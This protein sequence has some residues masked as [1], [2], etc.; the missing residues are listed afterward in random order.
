MAT[1][2]KS[3]KVSKE[4][5]WSGQGG[6][7]NYERCYH[8]HPPLKVGDWVI[9]GGS[10]IYPVVA[11][12]DVYIGFDRDMTLSERKPWN[13]VT[14]EQVFFPV[15]DGSVPQDPDEFDRL[16][17]WTIEQL[18][19]GKKVHVGCIGGHGRTGMFLA[20]LYAKVTNEADAIT[21]VRKNYC[22]K[23]VESSSQVSYLN[24]HYG[25]KKV[26][27]SRLPLIPQVF[28]GSYGGVGHGNWPYADGGGFPSTY[29]GGFDGKGTGYSP[30]KAKAS[31]RSEKIQ[32]VQSDKNVWKGALV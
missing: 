7:G 14:P 28:S 8:K 32:P 24:K 6:Q 3:K 16:L 4:D 22:H 27:G 20:A 18:G 1:K 10:C 26:E 23:A 21:Y 31:S 15:T 2:G 29:K 5:L 12:A 9:Y 11:D 25:I 13:G 17:N 19:A 30:P